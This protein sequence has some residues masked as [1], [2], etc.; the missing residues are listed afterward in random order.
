MSNLSNESLIEEALDW[1]DTWE[2]T[3]HAEKIRFHIKIGDMEELAL[4]V[5]NARQAYNDDHSVDWDEVI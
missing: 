5:A 4:D 2:G 3:A 1:A